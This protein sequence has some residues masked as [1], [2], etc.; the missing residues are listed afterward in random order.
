MKRALTAILICAAAAALAR[1]DSASEKLG[2]KLGLQCYTFRALSFF[3]TVDKA[4][5]LGIKYLEIYP[6]QKI[7]PD[8]KE[9]TSADMSEETAAAIRKKLK[10]AGGLRLVAY[11]VTAVPQ[12]EAGARKLFSWA[13][14]MGIEVIVT[15]TAPSELH[16]K[17][18][19]EFGIRWAIHNHPKT[20]PPEQVLEACKGRGNLV[21]ACCDTGHHYRA[22]RDPVAV[23]KQL[24]GRLMSLHFKDLNDQKQDVPFGEGVCNAKGMLAELKRQKFKGYL[25]IEYE[26]GSVEELMTN[27]ANCVAFYD[28]TCAALARQ[29]G[30]DSPAP[31]KTQ[32]RAG[33]SRSNTSVRACNNGENRI[34][35]RTEPATCWRR[36]FSVRR[37]V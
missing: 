26:R 9:V 36:L 12:D 24:Q 30:F 28:K 8:S 17:L 37:S 1:D 15:E 20:W 6:R 25:S 4:A 7:A 18:T 23:L 29:K 33:G 27:L 10:E 2:L 11:G 14:K 21:G 35:L 31:G 13:K 19:Q 3:E 16:D 5:A 32:D 22:G 34:A